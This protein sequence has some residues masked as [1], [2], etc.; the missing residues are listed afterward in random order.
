MKLVPLVPVAASVLFIAG[1]CGKT[2]RSVSVAFPV[3]PRFE[4][5]SVTVDVPA[6]D[7]VPAINP[8]EVLTLNPDGSPEAL[9]AVG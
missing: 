2:T 9:N 4:A 7:G 8:V 5:P 3:P 6:T 1:G